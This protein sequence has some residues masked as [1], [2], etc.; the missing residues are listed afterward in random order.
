M[1]IMPQQPDLSLEKLTLDS[2]EQYTTVCFSAM[3]F[4]WIFHLIFFKFQEMVML[5]RKTNK[6]TPHK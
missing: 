3:L 4:V 1:L 2:I 5:K 6:N